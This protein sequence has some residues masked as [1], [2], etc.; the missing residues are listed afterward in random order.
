MAVATLS[1]ALAFTKVLPLVTA[2]RTLRIAPT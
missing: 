1:R 2:W